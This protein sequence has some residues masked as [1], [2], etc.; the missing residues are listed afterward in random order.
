[1]DDLG[2]PPWLRKTTTSFIF[3]Q[4]IFSAVAGST[5]WGHWLPEFQPSAPVPYSQ[6]CWDILLIFLKANTKLWPDFIGPCCSTWFFG[7]DRFTE[8]S[9]HFDALNTLNGFLGKLYYLEPPWFIIRFPFK[10]TTLWVSHLFLNKPKYH[11]C[12]EYDDIHQNPSDSPII[13]KK[14]PRWLTAI[15]ILV[16]QI[17]MKNA[18]FSFF[19][20]PLNQNL[21]VKPS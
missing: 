18:I 10:Q 14:L 3:K 2:V 7:C 5:A 15:S 9:P 12:R 8:Q 20:L 11:L 16:G 6:A 13:T 21:L 1:M 4:S 17:P 19:K